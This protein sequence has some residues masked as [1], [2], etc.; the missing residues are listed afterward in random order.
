MDVFP[1]PPNDSLLLG[2]A[3]G[4]NASELVEVVM[5][6]NVVSDAP[7]DVEELLSE[8]VEFVDPLDERFPAPEKIPSSA[9]VRACPLAQMS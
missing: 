8:Y 4:G 5:V 7:S 3:G 2:D 1:V 6:A 9:N